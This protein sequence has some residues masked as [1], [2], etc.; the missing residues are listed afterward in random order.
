MLF[1]KY[2]HPGP[3]RFPLLAMVAVAALIV[4]GCLSPT[5]STTTST[6]DSGS[7]G[8]PMNFTTY[9]MPAIHQGHGLYEP[10]IDVGMDGAIYVSSHSTGVG[11]LPAPGYYSVDDGKTWLTLALAGPA[12]GPPSTQSAAPLFSDEIFIVAGPEGTAWG[13][14]I[15][16]RDYIIAGWCQNGA[17]LCY[18]NP[19]AYDNAQLAAQTPECQP[20]PLKDRPWAAY[21]N[22]TLLV[23]NNPGG[24]PIQFGIMTVPATVPAE[25]G[26]AVSGIQWNLCGSAGGF[27]PGIPDIR[28][29]GFFALPQ[30]DGSRYYVVTGHISDIFDLTTTDVFNATHRSVSEIGLYGQ[31]VFDA[32]GTLYV[33]A[34]NNTASGGGFAVGIRSDDTSFAT[35]RFF[36]DRP[37]SSVYFDG[38]KFGP[39][40]LVN[41]GLVDGDRTD[42][43]FGHLFLENG[44]P[45]LKNVHL[46]VDDG[47]VASRHVQ[48]A[49]VGP[50]GRAYMVMSEVS[51]NDDAAM[52]QAVGTTPLSVV[53]QTS[54]VTM[55]VRSTA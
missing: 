30:R 21:A 52:A 42:W 3:M 54:G 14:D 7:S 53:V 6:T 15:N 5:E 19:H 20:V 17:E 2:P 48:G 50:D 9:V 16:L 38:N 34:L 37:V 46:A 35:E 13:V 24:G 47:P 32:D 4:S 1:R 31:A 25:V 26:S 28:D 51:G 45:V 29:D 11:V 10:T 55:P 44:K 27:I 22:G 41:W 40:A 18:Y 12:Q 49:A 43:Y 39:G 36:F 8:E 23:V 33:G